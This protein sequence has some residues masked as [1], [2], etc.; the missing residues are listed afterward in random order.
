M[1][2]K[3]AAQKFQNWLVRNERP[4]VYTSLAIAGSLIMAQRAQLKDVAQYMETNA[5]ELAHEYYSGE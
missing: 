3:S 4:I 5:P 2:L 1:K